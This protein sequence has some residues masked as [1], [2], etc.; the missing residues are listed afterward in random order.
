VSITVYVGCY[1]T[2]DRKGR[3]EGISAFRMD[4]DSGEWTPLGLA[5]KTSNP[6]F[7]ASH[8]S[9]PVL[10]CVHGGLMSEISAFAIEGE[11]RLKPLGTWPS[12]GANPVH[13]DLHPSG[14]WLVVA[15]YTGASVAILPVSESGALGEPC[16]L[17]PL[18]GQPGPDPAEQSSPHPHDIP[19]HPSGEFVAVPDKGLDRVFIFRVDAQTGRYHP[20]EP[21]SVASAPGAGPRHVAFHPTEQ[22]AY[23]INE[24][25]STLT[26]YAFDKRGDGLRELQTIPSI[27]RDMGIRNTGS[28]VVIHPSGRWVYVSNRGQNS[29]GAFSVDAQTGTLAPLD[30]YPTGGDTPRAIALHPHGRF[31]YAA[32]QASD[33]ISTFR[34][35]GQDG[36]LTSSGQ[37]IATGSPSTLLF[38]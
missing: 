9:Q 35:D 28:E 13:L 31:L 3:G 33:T 38:V 37:V 36:T 5:A 32:N 7:L 29:V 27:P 30:W 8:P 4:E 6:S 22:W 12:G 23:V 24:L 19:F 10:Y 20:A 1:T 25:N 2:P 26:T 14:R 18:T 34:V 17:V 11:G 16:D 21:A 15:N